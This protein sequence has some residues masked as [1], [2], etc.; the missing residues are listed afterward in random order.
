MVLSIR[1]MIPK[2]KTKNNL[3][4][5]FK[6]VSKHSTEKYIFKMIQTHGHFFF[7]SVFFF[8]FEHHNVMSL[9]WSTLYSIDNEI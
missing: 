6:N 5:S 1:M 4:Y 7:Q 2:M 8:V 9:L 3:K